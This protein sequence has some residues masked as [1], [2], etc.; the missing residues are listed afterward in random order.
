MIA[1]MSDSNS[2]CE[3]SSSTSDFSDFK[4]ALKCEIHENV[5]GTFTT[6]QPWRFEPAG[7]PSEPRESGEGTDL[8]PR[9][10]CDRDS[11]EW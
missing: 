9:H 1:N 7:K 2:S 10:C 11:E 8:P 5:M 6:I 4:E 3:S